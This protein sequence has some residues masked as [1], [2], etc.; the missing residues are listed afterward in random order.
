MLYSE[1]VIRTVWEKGEE[2]PWR[3]PE[4]CLKDICGAIIFKDHYMNKESDYGWVIGYIVLPDE[5]GSDS[6][7]NL[8]PIPRENG[9][10]HTAGIFNFI[11]TSLITGEHGKYK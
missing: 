5:G 3:E 6:I 9:Q 4:V 7:E 10:L 8:Q 11:V 1:E 2:T